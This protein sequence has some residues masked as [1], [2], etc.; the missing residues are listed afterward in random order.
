MPQAAVAKTR[1]QRS[2]VRG[3]AGTSVL[4]AAPADVQQALGDDVDGL[5]WGPQVTGSVPIR[6]GARGVSGPQSRCR[7]T[8]WGHAD[9]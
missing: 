6:L 2:V 9:S 5:W 1:L 3:D 4:P 7:V 8:I